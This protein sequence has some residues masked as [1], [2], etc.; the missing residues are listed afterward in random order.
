MNYYSH[1]FYSKNTIKCTK[2]KVCVDK[3]QNS[4]FDLTLQFNRP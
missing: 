4:E 1:S 2:W 3:K